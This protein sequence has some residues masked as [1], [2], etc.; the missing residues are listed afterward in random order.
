MLSKKVKIEI[1][2]RFSGSILFEYESV[3]NTVAKTVM[4]AIKQYADLRY[5]DLTSADLRSADLTS[6]NL[7][8]ANL[9]SANLTSANL[10]S[11]DLRY[12]NL[13]SAN[14]RSA[15]LRYADLTSAK[16]SEMAIAM[17][18]I[19]PEGSIIGWKKCQDNKIVKLLIPIDAKRSHAFGRKCRAEFAE[20]LEITKGKRNFKTALSNWDKDFVY[21]VGKTVRPKNEFSEE[22]TDECASGLHFFITKIEA[23]N[24]N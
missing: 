6:A 24:Y 21:E 14:L 3:D 19:L 1:K 8:S 20:V 13:T 12:A 22:W 5:A 17:T 2:H 15:D 4:E 7:T 16:N 10:R 9:T 23:E 11:A 18:R